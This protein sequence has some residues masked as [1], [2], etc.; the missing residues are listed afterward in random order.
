MMNTQKVV[1]ALIYRASII[2]L[3][4]YSGQ[5]AFHRGGKREGEIFFSFPSCTSSRTQIGTEGWAVS[6]GISILSLAWLSLRETCQGHPFTTTH[7]ALV[8]PNITKDPRDQQIRPPAA[9]LP[10]WPTTPPL[11][12][13]LSHSDSHGLASLTCQRLSRTVETTVATLRKGYENS[14]WQMKNVFTLTI[15]LS[16]PCLIT[17]PILG[18]SLSF[19]MMHKWHTSQNSTWVWGSFVS[20]LWENINVVCCLRLFKLFS[21]KK[22]D[23]HLSPQALGSRDFNVTLPGCTL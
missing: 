20:D 13:F 18:V 10:P 19:W 23:L 11:L 12:F 1:P 16:F 17:P 8:S 7:M 14:Y 6:P 22:K 15:Y 2:R 21:K 5:G 9:D 3:N 4:V